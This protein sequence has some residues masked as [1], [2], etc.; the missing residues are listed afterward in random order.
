MS[1]EEPLAT[2]PSGADVTVTTSHEGG[3]LFVIPINDTIMVSYNAIDVF[4]N[5]AICFFNIYVVCK[6]MDIFF[7]ANVRVCVCVVEVGRGVFPLF[8]ADWLNPA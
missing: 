7:V 3:G 1:W 2:S 8:E 6:Y 5:S 4:G